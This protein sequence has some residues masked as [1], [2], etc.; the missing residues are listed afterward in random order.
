MPEGQ[1]FASLGTSRA[2]DRRNNALRHESHDRRHE[3]EQGHGR[4]YDPGDVGA[5][6]ERRGAGGSARALG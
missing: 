3:D 2:E 1:P 5:R 4:G 6:R